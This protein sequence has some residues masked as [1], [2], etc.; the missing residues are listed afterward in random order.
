MD[1]VAQNGGPTAM[2]YIMSQGQRYIDAVAAFNGARRSTINITS[3]QITGRALDLAVPQGATQAQQTALNALVEYGRQRSV[4]V[5]II[6]V[7][8]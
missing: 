1:M 4:T 7:P 6:V 8:H 2:Q 5:N 3:G